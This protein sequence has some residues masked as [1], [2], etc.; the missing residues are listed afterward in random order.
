MA[1]SGVFHPRVLRG[2]WF[3]RRATSLSS[4]WL[5][6]L[7]SVPLGKNWRELSVGVLVAAA[8]PGGVWI[9][10][11]DV[12]L[13]PSRQ[14]RVAGHLA[15]SIIGHRPAQHSGQAFHLAGKPLQRRVGGATARSALQSIPRIDCLTLELLRMTKRVLRST[16]VPTAGRLKAPLIRSPSQ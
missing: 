11:P 13:Q 4:V 1:S 5:M 9:A 14:F 7:R 8:L 15:A 10:E 3:I 12:D 6:S 2:R 16:T